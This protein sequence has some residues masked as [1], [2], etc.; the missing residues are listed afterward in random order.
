MKA[1]HKYDDIIHL[2]R[3]VSGKRARM[4]MIDRGAQFSPFA[5][6]V[7]YEAVIR[8]TARQTD[9][10]VEL[11]ESNKELLN[12]K[13][14]YLL[15]HPEKKAAFLC[16]QPDER[17]EGGSYREYSG[18]LKKVDIYQRRIVLMDGTQLPIVQIRSIEEVD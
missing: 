18:S 12:R 13:L 15:N 3:P 6:L 9:S 7:G 1:S 4:S 8:E 5:A 14:Q 11:D 16:F 17:K 10:E 2:Q